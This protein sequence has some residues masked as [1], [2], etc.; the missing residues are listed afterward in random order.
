MYA[1]HIPDVGGCSSDPMR[2]ASGARLPRIDAV[3]RLLLAANFIFDVAM[4]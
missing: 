4:Y 2:V 1:R 3:P